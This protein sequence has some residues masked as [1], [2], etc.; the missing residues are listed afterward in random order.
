[1]A[2]ELPPVAL[3]NV[4][5]EIRI[6]GLVPGTGVRVDAGGVIYEA[7]AGDD[8]TARVTGIIFASA[9]R[10][11]LDVS[12][13][14]A[15]SSAALRVLPGW[16]SLLPAFCAIVIA[17]LMRNVVPAMLLGLWFGA[18][19]LQS[20]TPQGALLGLLDIFQVFI[21]NVIADTDHA[22]IIVFTMLIGGMVGI[23]TRN[24]GMMSVVRVVVSRARSALG[25]QVAVWVMGIVIFFD[26]YANTLVVGNTARPITDQLKVSREKLAY[27]VDSTAA[28]VTSIALITTW[29]GYEVGLIDEALQDIGDLAGT[30]AYSIFL[31]S[32]PYGFYPLLAILFVLMVAV[33]GRDFGP[34][35]TAEVRARSGTIAGDAHDA[36]DAANGDK[37]EAK[38]DVPL[39]AVNAVVPIVA[40]VAALLG[41]LVVTGEGQTLRDIIGSADPYRAMVWASSISV[42]IAAAMTI[43]QRILSVQETVD[44]WYGG[45]R[46]TLFGMIILVLAWTM[47]DVTTALGA[48]GYLVSILGESLPAAWLPAAVFVLAGITSF[49]TGTSWG[50]MGILV[51]LVMPLA[52]AVMSA[53]GMTAAGDM[54]ILYSAV[55]CVLAGAVW[56]DH[57]SP[58]S[59]TTVLSSIA[60]GCNHIEHVRTQ[61]PYALLV[62]AVALAVG[63]VPGGYGA[64]PWVSLLAGGLVLYAVLRLRGSQPDLA[65]RR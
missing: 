47:S 35:F 56:G 46:A 59:D 9:G 7:L 3:A 13:G 34:M 16:V 60:S 43:G 2:V 22:A 19:A 42:V 27:I 20:F 63:T 10:Q 14:G 58:I 65:A 38:D 31:H 52:W 18:T 55:A 50:T 37:L 4:A 30:S 54:H 64:P 33:T 26:D 25:A 15:Q 5:A 11:P 53:N 51:P 12:A 44:A 36:G 48:K 8:G 23:I 29:I 28:P 45:A 1:M 41:G 32:I 49:A 62:G 17:L 6:T 40:L 21:V 39:R 24:G 61:M 57:C